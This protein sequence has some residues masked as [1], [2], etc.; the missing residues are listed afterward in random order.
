LDVETPLPVQKLSEERKESV[1]DQLQVIW[2][3]TLIWRSVNVLDAG[4]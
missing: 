2:L 4:H 1:D 3:Q